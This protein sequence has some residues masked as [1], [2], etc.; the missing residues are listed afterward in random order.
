MVNMPWKKK[1]IEPV[2]DSTNTDTPETAVE[3]LI[4]E[5]ESTHIGAPRVSA[6][7]L[8]QEQLRSAFDEE[9][10]EAAGELLEAQGT[11]IKEIVEEQRRII[12]EVIEEEKKAIWTRIG[13]IKQS[14][15]RL[16]IE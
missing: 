12:R 2:E 16:Q 11:A 6:R 9:L 10:K 1:P 4:Q 5:H 14:I 15:S 13:E 8:L 7:R 3:K